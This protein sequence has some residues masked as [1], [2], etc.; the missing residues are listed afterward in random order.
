MI[1]IYLAFVAAVLL[2]GAWFFWWSRKTAAEI[3]ADAGEEWTRLNASDPDL[4]AGLDEPRFRTVY[5]RVHFPRFPKYALAI[6]AAFVAS[7]PVTLG[8]LAFIAGGLE[9]IG[10]SADAANLAK[11][12]PV[13]GSIAGVSRDEQETIALYYVQDVVKFYYYFG[14]IFS[15]LAIIFVAMRRYHKRRPGYLREEIL[16][17]K[18]KG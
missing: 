7:L 14:I 15:W 8:L 9:S 5:R 13:E 1:E 10:M 11:S 3:A 2:A 17:E 4:V 12:I 16:A 6:A 18:A